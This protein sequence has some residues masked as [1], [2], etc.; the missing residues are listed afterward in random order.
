MFD[1]TFESA[2][3]GP[4]PGG[5]PE[6]KVTSVIASLD[7]TVEHVGLDRAVIAVGGVGLLVHATPQTLS[8]LHAGRPGRVETHLVVKEDA[9]TLFGFADRDEREVFEVLLGANGVGPRLALAILAVHRPEAVRR[10]VADEDEKA[11]TRVP[12][13]GPKLA[14]KIIVELA[15]RLVPT[16]EVLPEEAAPAPAADA[17]AWHADVVQ[18]M[19]GLGWS[20]KE[21]A[22][23]VAATLAAR[24]ELEEG[25]DVAALL[26]AT[27]R[28][29]GTAGAVRGGRGA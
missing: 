22:R 5:P 11:L 2:P 19:A 9:L 6:K 8:A 25:R 17:P 3:A 12:G 24:P 13:I 1:D 21:A 27:L 16:G 20:E 23:A 28:D 18:A 29:V 4:G 14:R 7:G 26:R 15:G 10:A